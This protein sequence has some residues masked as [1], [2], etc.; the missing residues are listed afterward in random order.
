M[1]TKKKVKMKAYHPE[2]PPGLIC[3]GTSPQ[4]KSGPSCPRPAAREE[5]E[6]VSPDEL[7]SYFPRVNDIGWMQIIG[8]LFRIFM[9]NM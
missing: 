6:P 9:N 1:K 3:G 2:P 5:D 8:D 4:T 7:P